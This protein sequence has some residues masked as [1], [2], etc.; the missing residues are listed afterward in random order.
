MNRADGKAQ[1]NIRAQR[2]AA[3]K[4][5]YRRIRG[6]KIGTHPRSKGPRLRPASRSQAA[7]AGVFVSS[8]RL[9]SEHKKNP[10]VEL[11][12]SVVEKTDET[13]RLYRLNLAVH[14][15]EGVIR[16]GGNVNFYYDDPHDVTNRFDFVLANPSFNVNAA[17]VAHVR[18]FQ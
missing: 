6:R 17:K 1:R 5:S 11:P 12:I 4:Q 2:Q 10:A 18:G 8:A 13:G 16:H 7:I 14:G 9:V 15:L 3:G